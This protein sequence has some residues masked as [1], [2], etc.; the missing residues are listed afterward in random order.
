MRAMAKAYPSNLT[1]D[2]CEL[3]I[4][5]LPVELVFLYQKPQ[6]TGICFGHGSPSADVFLLS[7][8]TRELF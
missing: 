6:V 2:Q 8:L 1:L 4:S 5:L 3:P 7:A